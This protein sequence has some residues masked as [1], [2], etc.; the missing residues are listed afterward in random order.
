MATKDENNSFYPEDA[1]EV[2]FA[3]AADLAAAN[4]EKDL[5]TRSIGSTEADHIE[6]TTTTEV[7][8][9]V[10]EPLGAD[11]SDTTDKSDTTTKNA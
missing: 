9:P 7:I 3:A 5:S 8:N 6:E 11:S 4:H 2:N 10:A 1:Q